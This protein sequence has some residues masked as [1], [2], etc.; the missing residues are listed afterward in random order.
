M[1]K[2]HIIFLIGILCC[3]TLSAQRI[4][5]WNNNTKYIDFHINNGDLYVYPL[6]D[7]SVRIRLVKDKIYN[8]P[9]LVYVHRLITP[10]YSVSEK[11]NYVFIKLKR[12]IVEVNIATGKIRY[13]D[14]SH[15]SILAEY[16]RDINESTVQGERTYYVRQAFVSPKDEY[17]YGLGQFQDGYLNVRNLMRRLT[18]VNT[19]ISNPFILS[20]K[21]Y[22]LLWNN[23]GLTEFNSSCQK[24]DLLK[25]NTIAYK[26]EVNVTTTEG[27]KKEKRESNRYSA[28]LNIKTAGQYSLML[29]VGQ[30]M[31]HR[32]NLVVDAKT[33]I[34]MNNLWLPPTA[35]S[36]VYLSAG[37]HKLTADLSNDDI[38]VVYYKLVDNKTTFSSPVAN[39]VDYT[40]F[41]GIPEQV[42]ASYRE[43]TGEQPMMPVWA[44]GYIHCR[45]RFHSQNEIL[46][47]ARKFRDEK[48]PVDMIVQDW[49][50]WGKYG[51]NAMRFDEN[52]YPNPSLMVDSLHKM[53]IRFMLSVWSKI[54]ANSEVGQQMSINKYF[55]PNTSWIDFFSTK[56]ADAYWKYFNSRL[57][58]PYKIDAWWQDATEPENDDLLGRKVMRDSIPGEVF[59]DVYPLFVNKTVYEGCRKDDPTRRT[60]ILTR[61]GFTGIQKYGVALWS[62]DVGNDWETLRR[63]ITGGL[64]LMASGIPWWTYDAGGFF[65]PNNQYEDKQYHERMLRWLQISTFLPLMRVHGYMSNTEF[66]NYGDDVVRLARNAINLRYRL[67]PYIYSESA[68]VSFN[69]STLMRP[70]VMDFTNDVVALSQKYEYMF[71]HSLLIIPVLDKSPK[72]WKVYLPKENGEWYDF[73]NG[74]R[75][76]S[77]QTIYANVTLEHI[78]V[79]V[80]AGSIIPFGESKCYTT[81]T[82]YRASEIVIYPGTD[83]DISL[84]EDEGVNY[85][86]EK[87]CYSIIPIRWNDKT[88]TLIIGKCEGQY[89][90]MLHNRT[91]SIKLVNGTSHV[92][93][94]NGNIIKVKFNKDDQN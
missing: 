14:S 86:Y 42:I 60:M 33:V 44:L 10:T 8:L 80:K 48:I 34:D 12:L 90:G 23:Y 64:G 81:Q 43:V 19:Q 55:I 78:P 69:G 17:L 11:N 91:L 67:L 29:D 40:V 36:I 47:T 2:K 66:W 58:Q 82:M 5:S 62:G 71:G 63:Q 79:Y 20:N 52:Y 70:L 21:G 3:I 1:D 72:T 87:K 35:S 41:A 37:S 28:I 74:K 13:Y 6:T 39:A 94:Y 4:V 75:Y 61:S 51:W 59:R 88:H 22:G 68:G 15:K 25:S 49:Q 9:E 93:N 31:A 38:P 53:D 89:K 65:R 54:D 92:V 32:Q 73:W 16:G 30:K 26:E 57:L 83:G 24:V 56:A 85:N 18:Q 46:E 27:N 45:E 7:N 77:G 50:Y 76:K 84:Y